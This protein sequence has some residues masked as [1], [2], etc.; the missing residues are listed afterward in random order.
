MKKETKPSIL[1]L[2]GSMLF[3]AVFYTSIFIFVLIFY[4]YFSLQVLKDT[5]N[6]TF[7][8]KQIHSHMVFFWLSTGVFVIVEIFMMY[9]FYKKVYKPIV[10]IKRSINNIANEKSE[11]DLNLDPRNELYSVAS[12]I[13]TVKGRIRELLD[14]EYTA[15]LLKKQ[16][17]LN[18]LQS[19][20]NP[21][22][23]YNTLESIRSQAIIEGVDGIAKMTKALSSMFRYSISQKDSIVTFAQEL[24]NTEN[25]LTIQ[26]YRFFNKF[27]IIKELDEN[28]CSV[29]DCKIPNLTIQPIVEN[30]IFHGLEKKSG[31]G[32]IKISAYPTQNRIVINIEDDGLGMPEH[33]VKEHNGLFNFD[34][35]QIITSEVMEK[36]N[37]G[38][39]NVNERI[40]LNFGSEYGLH[41]YSTLEL[42]TNV[43]ITL[44]KYPVPVPRTLS[45]L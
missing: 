31:T 34:R 8:Y 14:G 9:L 7:L 16:A 26:Q 43:E 40:K 15:K 13:N 28:D 22:F 33:K 37:I 5:E 20:I 24:K 36:N 19:Q 18:A 30:A 23:L 3:V 6:F 21:H 27:I 45:G 17:E 12:V 32:T 10:F 2:S 38:L 25:Y 4:G 35:E 11:I 29:M 41:I 42:G 1:K 39:V 44:P